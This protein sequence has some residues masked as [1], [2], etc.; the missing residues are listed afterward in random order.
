SRKQESMVETRSRKRAPSLVNTES[1]RSKRTRPTTERLL[2]KRST[3]IVSRQKPD[4]LSVNLQTRQV[5]KKTENAS[6]GAFAEPQP[7]YKQLH[8]QLVKLSSNKR[9]AI[10][11]KYFRVEEYEDEDVLMGITVPDV[12]SVSKD[13]GFFDYPLLKQLVLSKYHEERLLA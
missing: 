9:A 8:Q 2:K 1:V 7:S 13:T 3:K 5:L 10:Q 6:A 12:R 4:A 11:T